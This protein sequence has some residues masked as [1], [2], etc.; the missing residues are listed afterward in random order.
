MYHI[1]AD[2]NM[3]AL[4][5]FE[6]HGTVETVP[7]RTMTPAVVKSADALLVRSV[8]AVTPDLLKDAAVSF[9]GSAT[10]GTDH[11]DM[12]W[13]KQQGIAFAHAPG[14]NAM[15]VAE[16]VLQVMV[17]WLLAQQR[18]PQNTTLAVI[19]HGNVGRRVAALGEALGLEVLLVDPFS[20][21]TKSTYST[22]ESA[23]QAHVLSCHVP[24]TFKGEHATY[25]LLHE[26]RLAAMT[27]SQLLINTSRGPVVD[28]Q[29]LKALLMQQ[30]GPT[31]WL[32]VWEHEPVVDPALFHLVRGGTPHIAGYTVEG[33]WRG[34]W[35]L[36]E[37]WRKHVGDPLEEQAHM[38]QLAPKRVWK[39]PI[40]TLEDVHKLLVAHY[41]MMEDHKRL[42]E[43]LSEEDTA[44][45][46][47]RL[48]RDYGQRY[49]LAG[50]LC[51]GPVAA[52][53]MPL[54]NQLGV[55]CVG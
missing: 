15:A 6:Q 38:P 14:C 18:S 31:A 50:I 23:L 30:Q 46:F 29:A 12:A 17:S 36:Y 3:P 54:L 22:L 10:I 52:Q 40:H 53:W 37:A 2:E 8:T 21:C 13:L 25:H 55:V 34:T 24:L 33:K 11:V 47:D 43:S 44:Q 42:K 41:P 4:S 5:L 48:R 32:D 7:G 39:A 49:E 20:P 9:V 51:Q 1:V 35:M 19:G 45:A 27:P 28:N 16:Y 26:D